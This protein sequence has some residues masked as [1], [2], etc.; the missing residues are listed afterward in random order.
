M[1]CKYEKTY[2]LTLPGFE[3]KGK[4]ILS[5]ADTKRLLS[6]KVVIEEKMDGANTGIIRIGGPEM[7][8]LQKRGSLVDASE[9]EQFNRFKAWAAENW[10]NI[11]WIPQGYIVYGEFMYAQHHIYYDGLPDWFLVFDVRQGK[12]FL[13]FDERK[14]FCEEIGFS[15]VPTI[16]YGFFNRGDLVNLVPKKSAY[17]ER[18]EG[19]VIKNY[20]K[21]YYLRAKVVWPDFVKEVDESDHWIKGPIRTNRVV[22]NVP[23]IY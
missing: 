19:I 11:A 2:R 15:M 18:A 4:R 1:F 7:F 13:P 10:N 9:H 23:A 6:G 14:D 20:S 3:V 16:D 5:K 21:K 12:H 22:K 8:R 17:G